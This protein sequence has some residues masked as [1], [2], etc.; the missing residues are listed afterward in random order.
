MIMG[1]CPPVSRRENQGIFTAVFFFDSTA[2]FSGE[3]KKPTTGFCV[4]SFGWT[5]QWAGKY[6]FHLGL[7][8]KDMGYMGLSE[9]EPAKKYPMC[10]SIS[11]VEISACYDCYV[12]PI[13]HFQTHQDV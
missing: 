9:N 1:F 5:E 4:P 10:I 8:S 7:D 11:P 13:P 2:F 12:V 6:V 3:N